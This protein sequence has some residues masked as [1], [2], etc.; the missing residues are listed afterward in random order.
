M[1]NPPASQE[2]FDLFEAGLRKRVPLDCENLAQFGARR[3]Q[4]GGHHS[5]EVQPG[6]GLPAQQNRHFA[7]GDTFGTGRSRNREVTADALTQ[8]AAS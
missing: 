5:I 1:P 6:A 7:F 2:R 3:R 8:Y 4:H